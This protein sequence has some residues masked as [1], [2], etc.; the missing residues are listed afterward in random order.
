MPK[1]NVK[2]TYKVP[3]RYQED[4][5]ELG[6]TE[7]YV[8]DGKEYICVDID[9]NTGYVIGC[10]FYD[11]EE[12]ERPIGLEDYRLTLD[13]KDEP[14]L[15]D[16]LDDKGDDTPWKLG[17]WPSPD[18]PETMT[19]EEMDAKYMELWFATPEGYPNILKPKRCIPREIYDQYKIKYNFDTDEFEYSIIEADRPPL[20]TT[21][22]DVRHMRDAELQNTDSRVSPDQPESVQAEWKEYRQ[23]LR[24]MPTKFKE[25]GLEPW[26]ALMAFPEPPASGKSPSL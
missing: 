23:K 6:L 9:K 19:D 14:M 3:D 16:I 25:M 24:D 1:Y 21:W 8:Y 7:E 4:S 22:D 26:Q 10:S 17:F 11:P 5:W 20:D 13:C 12:L 15:C 18:D 2:F